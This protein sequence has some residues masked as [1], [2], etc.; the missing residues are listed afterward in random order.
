MR[1]IFWCT[2]LK[3]PY[4]PFKIRV[5]EPIRLLP[6]EIRRI[7]LEEAYWNVFGI[8]SEDIYIDL[9]TDSGTSGLSIYQLAAIM[10]SDEAYAG[11]RSWYRFRDAVRNILGVDYILPTHQGRS[12]ERI[13]YTSLM[14]IRRAYIVPANTHFDT[15]RAVILNYGG[16]PIDLPKGNALDRENLDRFK[17]GFD[18]DRLDRLIREEGAEK[19]AFILIV[20][21]NNTLAGQPVSM[22][23][24]RETREIADK[25]GLPLAMDISRYAENAYFIK[26]YEE[27]YR[28]KSLIEIS[29][30]MLSYGDHFMMSA[31]KDGL[32][33][34]GGFIATRD[35]ELFRYMQSKVVLEEGFVTYGGMTG[36]DMEEIA[37]GMYEALQLDYM[38]HRVGQVRYLGELLDSLGIPVIKPYGG[39]AIYIDAAEYLSHVLREYFPAD[40]LAAYLYL[41]GGIRGVGL[42]L[43]AFGDEG[44]APEYELLRL[45]IPRRTYTNHHIEYIAEVFRELDRKRRDI[46]GLKLV[47]QPKIKGVRHFLARL[48]PVKNG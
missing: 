14:D 4:E 6:R 19:I 28:D 22:E 23:N 47:W 9:L 20:L 48:E 26:M 10:A 18:L 44:E 45:A 29:R 27:G 1:N 30:E 13:L 46:K 33:A 42:G 11:S 35:E 16:R 2:V 8:R 41:E 5:V 32:A 34:M 31:K 25:Y 38:E 24:I 21:T 3:V 37:V 39:H 15:G 7:K 40:T 43:L 17:G 36:R 12:A